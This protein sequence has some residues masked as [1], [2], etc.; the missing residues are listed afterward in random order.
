MK[1]RNVA[2]L[3]FAMCLSGCD[4]SGGNSF[5]GYVEGEFVYLASPC[6][7]RLENL[8][9]SRGQTV[10]G[11]T[12]LYELEADYERHA[13]Q[14]A[15]QEMLAAS[16][17]LGDM[18]TGKRPEEVAMAVAQLNQAKAEEANAITQLRRNERLIKS[19]GV[20]QK[21]LDDSMA[22][23]K[24]ASARVTELARQVDVYNLPE[25]EKLIEAQ[26]AT[27]RSAEARVA[28]ARWE[29][30]QKRIHAPAAGLVYDTLYRLG[31]WVAAGN[32]VIQLLPPGN[33]KIRFFVPE[34][35]I[36]QVQCGQTVLFRM[37]GRAEPLRASVSYVS[38]S[39]EYTPP[40]IYS[41]ETRSKLV[42]MVEAHPDPET[43]S[44]LHPGQPVS[45]SLP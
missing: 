10:D 15:E 16:A 17:Q 42:F 2:F 26:Q 32:P 40:I 13:L 18:E 27:V 7:G 39:A 22:S 30:D 5:Q 6:A 33:V 29:L 12:L 37:D 38:T 23:A 14:Q 1:L 3:I 19:R 25:R 45:V 4:S 43:A 34:A 41:N 24:S 44:S 35:T 31:E 36:A 20:S 21:E 9:V 11:G 8:P 28:Q